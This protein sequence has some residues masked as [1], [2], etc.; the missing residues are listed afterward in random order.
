MIEFEIQKCKI[1]YFNAK[2]G[3]WEPFIENFQVKCLLNSVKNQ[4]FVKVEF[5]KPIIINITESCLQNLIE[6]YNS[7]MATPPFEMD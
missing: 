2:I 7:W 1:F 5:N 6:S 3:D 4:K